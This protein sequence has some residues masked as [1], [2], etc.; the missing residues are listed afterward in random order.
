MTRTVSIPAPA[1][2]IGNAGRDSR[3]QVGA[4][5]LACCAV[6]FGLIV[7][8]GVTRLTHS[9][10]SIVE[11]APLI[12]TLPPLTEQQWLETFEKYRQT[13]EYVK[14][15]QGMS[16]AAFKGIFWWEY[17]HRL[18]A[19]L[20]GLVFFVPFVWFL[21]R[22]RVD[23]RLAWKLAGIFVLGALQGG[24][25]WYMVR[26][27]LVDNPRVSHLRLT[28]HLGIAFA[29]FAAMFWLALGLLHPGTADRPRGDGTGPARFAGAIALLVFVQ[30]LSG[31]LVAGI[32]AGF[33][34]NT[35]P[36]MADHVIP[37]GIMM[38]DPWPANFFYNVATIQFTHRVIAWVLLALALVLWWRARGEARD[39]TLPPGAG[40]AVGLLLAAIAVQ[41]ALGVATLVTMVPVPLGA[42]HQGGAVVVFAAALYAAHA[43]R[44]ASRLSRG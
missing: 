35:F 24:M 37:P 30:V 19:R 16:L 29:I 7:I 44:G 20:L 33:A 17:V 32:R 23:R 2:V 3:R 15:N 9:G 14:V 41:F 43:L 36:L 27:G 31:G 40:G 11:W 22:R 39:G 25:G 10:L 21:A 8:G 5:L 34:Y 18:I 4:W 1:P 6:L 12:G 42:A 38:L 13:P 26:S 28:A